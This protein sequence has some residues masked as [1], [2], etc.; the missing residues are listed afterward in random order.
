MAHIRQNGG[1]IIEEA[2]KLGAVK[3]PAYEVESEANPGLFYTVWCHSYGWSCTCPSFSFVTDHCKHIKKVMGMTEE[4]E[5]YE[6]AEQPRP[7]DGT[8]FPWLGNIQFNQNGVMYNVRLTGHF[9]ID[10]GTLEEVLGLRDW[11]IERSELS[12]SNS[13]EIAGADS[14]EDVPKCPVHNIS[15]VY[16][17]AGVSR[18]SGKPYA[19]FWGCPERDCRKTQN[20]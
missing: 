4:I 7:L 17:K 10:R 5:A 19:A 11:L 12:A 3:V 20:A 16:R 13:N 8:E 14:S 2:E 6:H 15:M 9:D 18:S 1:H